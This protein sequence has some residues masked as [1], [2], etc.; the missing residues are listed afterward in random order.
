M[1]RDS[2]IRD[3]ASGAVPSPPNS[4]TLTKY[5][6]NA[7]QSKEAIRSSHNSSQQLPI[8]N[9]AA[10]RIL[11]RPPAGPPQHDQNQNSETSPPQKAAWSQKRE[12]SFLNFPA[13]LP[14]GRPALPLQTE[15][16]SGGSGR[17]AVSPKAFRTLR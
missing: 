1:L 6:T 13:M 9:N 5:A 15:G 12:R 16:E 10:L 8:S 14:N 3:S 4:G 2:V 17:I 7:R 11:I